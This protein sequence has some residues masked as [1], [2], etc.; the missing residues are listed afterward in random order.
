MPVYAWAL[1]AAFR[2][3]HYGQC[4]MS[5]HNLMTIALFVSP[6]GESKGAFAIVHFD[7]PKSECLFLP[8]LA[9]GSV[10]SPRM[11]ARALDPL[12]PSKVQK[13]SYS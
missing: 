13:P 8:W 4:V 3:S 9:K 10:L 12:M 5:A 6:L 2:I 11:H 7:N 1:K